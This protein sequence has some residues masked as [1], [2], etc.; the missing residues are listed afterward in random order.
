MALNVCKDCRRYFNPNEEGVVDSTPTAS[1]VPVAFCGP[2]CQKYDATE[3]I[4]CGACGEKVPHVDTANGWCDACH[5][6]FRVFN[7]MADR[8]D[9]GAT[10][11]ES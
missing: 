11:M 2:C 10:F 8:M 5:D 9:N 1:G 4:D 7:D 6:D 3:Y